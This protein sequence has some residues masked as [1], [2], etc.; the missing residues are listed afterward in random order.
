MQ[1]RMLALLATAT[2]AGLTI[3]ACGGGGSSSSSSGGGSSASSAALT[4]TG[5]ITLVQGKDVSGF[6]QGVL[7]GW[8]KLHPDQKAR[9]IEL[10]ESADAQ[11][12]QMIQNATSKSD[13][14]DVLVVDNVWTSEF[15]ANRYIEPLPEAE[16]PTG[17]MLKP[18]IDSAACSTTGPT[19]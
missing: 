5:P 8:N 6:V 1:R 13:A 4:G 17:E 12:A 3:T 9:L 15:A 14:Y 7:D 19:C 10:P 16:F 2:A 18:V 11:R